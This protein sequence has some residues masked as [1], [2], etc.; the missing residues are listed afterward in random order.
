MITQLKRKT[1]D[2]LCGLNSELRSNHKSI[3]RKEYDHLR[4]SLM[5]HYYVGW[6][7]ITNYPK[8]AFEDDLA[9]HLTG[10][11]TSDRREIIPWINALMPLQGRSILE[12]GCGTGASTI[13][14]AE[15]GADV[16]AIDIDEPA[17][18]VAETRASLYGV[19]C[20]Y[21]ASNGV[22]IEDT[23]GTEKFDSVLFFACLEHMTLS[24]RIASLRSSWNAL[25]PN[26]LLLI[27]ESPN[28]LWY[29]DHHTSKLP[30]FMWLPDG[31]AFDYSNR[32]PVPN[33]GDFYQIPNPENLEHFLRRGRGVS[34][35]EI[36]LAIAPL[37][38]LS[39]CQSLGEYQF[40]IHNIRLKRKDRLYKRLMES[41]ATSIPKC[42]FDPYINIA[43]KKSI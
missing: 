5:T 15:Q 38:E 16:T 24:E 19:A 2:H 34:Y 40:L 37:A 6:R 21:L 33:F 17:I 10:R 43:L 13:A 18:R 39:V 27:V 4:S 29:F 26:G 30:F 42:F 1:I 12:I 41:S 36:E 25:K 32:S 20:R 9:A 35:H 11:L 14:L 28:R 3:T 23:V 7:S 31:L 8:K 22:A